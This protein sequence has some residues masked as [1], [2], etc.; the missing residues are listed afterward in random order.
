MPA[1]KPLHNSSQPVSQDYL[2]CCPTPVTRPKTPQATL[3]SRVE[4][5]LSLDPP[6]TEPQLHLF[7]VYSISLSIIEV[8]GSI[9]LHLYICQQLP[10]GGKSQ[11]FNPDEMK[12]IQCLGIVSACVPS[13][14]GGVE[15]GLAMRCLV[16]GDTGDMSP[17]SPGLS[18]MSLIRGRAA[19]SSA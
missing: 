6:V 11:S 18:P 12:Y 17:V 8:T 19:H 14:E 10:I 13:L 15:T 7:V 16:T 3:I 2:G 5:I 4:F 9:F 1:N